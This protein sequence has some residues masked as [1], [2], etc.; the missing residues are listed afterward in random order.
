MINLLYFAPPNLY[1]LRI[2]KGVYEKVLK[3]LSQ[4]LN[5][6]HE[7]NNSTEYWRIIIGPWLQVFLGIVFDRWLSIKNAIKSE[8]IIGTWIIDF[9]GK[10]MVPFD[11]KEAESFYY[12]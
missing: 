6:I 11:M 5:R 10:C 7:T 2:L 4:N 3:I 12:Y 9:K 1:E 8:E